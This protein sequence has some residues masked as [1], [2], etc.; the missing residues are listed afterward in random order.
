M[1]FERNLFLLVYSSMWWLI[2]LLLLLIIFYV[3]RSENLESGGSSVLLYEDFGQKKLAY[4]FQGSY[5]KEQI[6]INLKS[7]DINL[8]KVNETY[9]KVRRVEIW[10]IGDSEV[11]SSESDFYNSYL[12]PEYALRANPAR[13][14][15]IARVFPGQRL[16]ADIVEPVKKIWL[17]AFM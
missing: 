17:F 16:K 1:L 9:D 15:L 14:T 7:V 13:Y 5:I 10:R 4:S 6:K 2:I 8:E 3:R 11:S 12:E